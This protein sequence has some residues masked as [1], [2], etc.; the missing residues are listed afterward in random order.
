M[1][2]VLVVGAG[3]VGLFL[4][5]ELVR[6]GLRPRIVDRRTQ[7]PPLSRAIA[8]QPRTLEA[9][10]GSGVSARLLARGLKVRRLRFRSGSAELDV[11]LDDLPT[12]HPYVLVL[13]QS[14][15]ERELEERAR[16]LGILVERGVEL[17]HLERGEGPPRVLLH[18]LSDG[19]E[20]LRVYRWVVGCDGATSAVRRWTDGDLRGRE[21]GVRFLI[22][23][24]RA[25]L[26]LGRDESWL[27][28]TGDGLC[29]V[30]P[31]PGGEDR[32]RLIA[33]TRDSDPIVPEA[34]LMRI[35][36]EQR[37]GL[38]AHVEQDG[39]VGSFSVLERV[40]ERYR[41]GR[42]L[43]A[44]D[45]AHTHSPIGGQGMNTGLQDAHNLAWKLALVL[46]GLADEALIDS[47]E[48][49]RRPVARAV[50]QQ[51][52][53][54]TRFAVARGAIPQLVRDRVVGFLAG[55]GLVQAP[56]LRRA[57]EIDV[58]YRSSPL[59]SEHGSSPS[60]SA[61][62][63][64]D[65][66]PDVPIY[67]TL[68]TSGLLRSARHVLLLFAGA[69]RPPTTLARLVEV[70]RQTARTHPDTVDVWLVVHAGNAPEA[71]ADEPSLLLD[72]DGHL[73]AVFG[74]GVATAFL[75]RPDGYVGWRCHP[76]DGEKLRER[77][78]WTSER[79]P[80]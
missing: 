29:A 73:N 8:I 69:D 54:A 3:P 21:A 76:I 61:L 75:V 79:T 46:R 56:F 48:A 5:I 52:G 80:G 26:P 2:D 45:A 12:S 32:W 53:Q 50:T 37:A 1:E 10:D 25:T 60:P 59:S 39:W 41:R 20:E 51:T 4:A 6:H 15:T 31:L 62:R 57:A 70:A 11:P 44:G 63:A 64:G 19:A 30:V 13:P 24:L 18:R 14:D 35:V 22:G 27:Y 78:S 58:S 16:E 77:L 65:H 34:D 42:V 67:R 74:A 49:E 47:Y 17:V 23:D 43:L 40:E 68:R 7:H 71:C 55:F 9:L 28:T 36:L 38:R 72:P 66:V 33:D